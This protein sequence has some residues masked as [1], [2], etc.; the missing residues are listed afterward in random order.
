MADA[1]GSGR[2][3][4]EF[5]TMGSGKSAAAIAL[6]KT[7]KM[8]KKRNA[9]LFK[10]SIDTRS[11]GA[12]QSRNGESLEA[13]TFTQNDDLRVVIGT[14]DADF[15]IVDEAQFLT[16]A[17]VEQLRGMADNMKKEIHCF[18]LRSDFRARLF[19]GTQRLMELAD[20]LVN[21]E[22]LCECGRE[23][24]VNARL[25]K[26]GRVAIS[27]QVLEV[28]DLGRY[29]PMCWSCYEKAIGNHAGEDEE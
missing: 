27:G 7:E 22:S 10:S 16:T 15:I 14:R 26:A 24:V 1:V 20:D 2:L 29:K 21:I 25:N 8:L 9:A 28:G 23:A 11:P 4:F 17:Q 19:P 3:V 6:A 5:G 18:G 12:I 13:V